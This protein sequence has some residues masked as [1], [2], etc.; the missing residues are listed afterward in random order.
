MKTSESVRAQRSYLK[1]ADANRRRRKAESQDDELRRRVYRALQQF[2]SNSK[3]GG[4]R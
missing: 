1:N 3:S 4:K 2:G